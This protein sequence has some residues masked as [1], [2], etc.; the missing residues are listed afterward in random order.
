MNKLTIKIKLRVQDSKFSIAETYIEGA[1]AA[2]TSSSVPNRVAP[3]V[4]LMNLEVELT[5]LQEGLESIHHNLSDSAQFRGSTASISSDTMNPTPKRSSV[6]SA[7]ANSTTPV[8]AAYGI[9]THD[10]FGDSFDPFTDTAGHH[11]TNFQLGTSS[12]V[13]PAL[14]T[15]FTT[16]PFAQVDPFP[17]PK[18]SGDS[19]FFHSDPF[20]SPSGPFSF[21]FPT[22]EAVNTN[23]ARKTSESSKAESPVPVVRSTNI[24]V[25]D[26]VNKRDAIDAIEHKIKDGWTAS[27]EDVSYILALVSGWPFLNKHSYV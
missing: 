4:D 27:F 26:T 22:A 17:G 6:S 11:T 19:E 5:S 23:V 8:P 16:D 24:H 10:P 12:K 7:N 18:F 25:G 2:G 1:C 13:G 3:E 20:E 15:S 14:T 21:S 9:T